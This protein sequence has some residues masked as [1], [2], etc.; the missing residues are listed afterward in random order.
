M[1]EENRDREDVGT[2][3]V[4]RW[5]GRGGR[6]DHGGG[7]GVLKVLGTEAKGTEQHSLWVG[8][9]VVVGVGG[10]SDHRLEL[11]AGN[12]KGWGFL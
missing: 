1:G 12:S 8:V 5:K 11:G 4:C 7:S 2:T 9:E 3:G 10:P 6:K